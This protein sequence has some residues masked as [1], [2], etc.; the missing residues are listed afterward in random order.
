MVRFSCDGFRRYH[1]DF[2]H[3]THQGFL[4]D[5]LI[6]QEG[7]IRFSVATYLPGSRITY[8]QIEEQTSKLKHFRDLGFKKAHYFVI[9]QEF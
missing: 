3:L 7:S 4:S 5:D 6:S 1:C 8:R 9:I 2:N